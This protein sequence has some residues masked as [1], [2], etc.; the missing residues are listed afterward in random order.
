VPPPVLPHL[1]H[2]GFDIRF[3]K[4]PAPSPQTLMSILSHLK[5]SG[6][7][8]QSFSLRLSDR[9]IMA[10]HAFVEQLLQLH[11]HTLKRISLNDC[12]VSM[13]SIKA[14]CKLSINLIALEVPLPVKE[15]VSPIVPN[16][17]RSLFKLCQ[18]S[19]VQA[20]ARSTSLESV[21]DT[22]THAHLQSLSRENVSFIMNSC[23]SLK[24]IVSEHRV[25]KVYIHICTLPI[26]C[27]HTYYHF[28]CRANAIGTINFASASK[29]CLVRLT[30]LTG[31]WRMGVAPIR[32]A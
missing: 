20:I 18:T 31:F 27:M 26:K 24:T 4:S 32:P 3:S 14:I 5:F 28:H 21:T 10:P 22:E 11:A 23:V 7:A 25:W 17:W 12:I 15:V 6:P 30:A 29:Q 2:L 8:L 1:R 9:H 13:E 19:F 16:S